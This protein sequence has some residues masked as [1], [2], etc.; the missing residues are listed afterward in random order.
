MSV[1]S[2]SPA[3]MPGVDLPDPRRWWAL[4]VIGL[5][6][7]M[8]VL[9]VTI[10]NIALPSAQR[11]LEMSDATRQWV[12]TAYTLAFGGFLLLG[13]RFGDLLGRRR[14]LMVGLVGFAA[15]SALGGAAQSVTMLLG[16]R[17]LQG[18]F[19]ALLAPSALSLLA[20]TFRN[21][22]ERAKAFGVFGAIAGGGSAIGLILGG[23]LTEFA[24]WRWTLLIN[25]PVAILAVLGARAF[26]AADVRSSH[27]VRFDIPGAL[28]GTGGLLTLV[29][30]FNRAEQDGW[31]AAITLVALASAAALLIAFVFVERRVANPM[32]P[33][34]IVRERN[35]AGAYLAV[36]INAVGLFSTFFFLTF[37]LQGILTYSPI[38]SGFSF[39]PM[40][41]AVVMN[42]NIASR[43]LTRVRPRLLLGGGMLLMSA[44]LLWLTQLDADSSYLTHVVPALVLMGL[45]LGWTMVPAISTATANVQPAD[46]GVASA[47]VNT[48]QQV[49]A[50]IGTSLMSTIAASATASYFDTHTRDAITAVSGVVHGYN[51]ATAWAAGI[52]LAGS[53]IVVALVSTGKLGSSQ[54]APAKDGAPAAST[55]EVETELVAVPH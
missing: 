30:G 39:L 47:M 29:Y 53:V 17:A 46:T 43:L 2:Q 35:R 54:A 1:P 15:A 44:G 14:T 16:A 21:P 5:A 48:S 24:S 34:R 52:L 4:A 45:G 18:I 32:L 6:Q 40:T 11:S 27:R 55:A 12:I 41:A 42:A 3:V 37:Y 38:R 33:M 7:L 31:G 51:V 36:G 10:V 28:L 49:G 20:L 22:V 8:L 26:I 50:S 13:G 19:G 9:D 23:A 25:V